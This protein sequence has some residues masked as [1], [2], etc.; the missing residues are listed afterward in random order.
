MEAITYPHLFAV[1]QNFEVEIH[2]VETL[3]VLQTITAPSITDTVTLSRVPS[4]A[5]CCLEALARKFLMVPFNPGE[6]F[7]PKR[8]DEE[9]QISRRLAIVSS[10]IYLASTTS[11][12]CL[13]PIPWIVQADGFFDSNRVD[14]ALA[15]ASSQVIDETTFDAE[16]L[17]YL[18][19]TTLMSS[20][21]TNRILIKRRGLFSFEKLVSKKL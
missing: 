2:S 3:Q 7:S 14:E 9:V 8:R 12:G 20:S 5:S 15:L 16:R 4:G 17:V 11:V 6:T 13:L 10:R 19:V 1:M 21:M 18:T